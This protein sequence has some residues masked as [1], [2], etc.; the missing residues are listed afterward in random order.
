MGKPDRSLKR[1]KGRRKKKSKYAGAALNA[2]LSEALGGE[3]SRPDELLFFED[4]GVSDQVDR[5]AQIVAKREATEKQEEAEAIL[6][7]IKSA[8][9]PVQKKFV[10]VRTS[11][12]V[13]KVKEASLDVTKSPG[14]RDLWADDEPLANRPVTNKSRFVRSRPPT[15]QKVKAVKVVHPAASYNPSVDDLKEGLQKA[16]DDHLDFAKAKVYS[17]PNGFDE[18]VKRRKSRAIVDEEEKDLVS[19]DSSGSSSDED[20]AMGEE[21]EQE[22]D[23][24]GLSDPA[25]TGE[26][27]TTRERNKAK[28]K[29]MNEFLRKQ[30]L[31]KEEF[32]HQVEHL[33][34]IES[35]LVEE[36]KLQEQ[37]RQEKK[38]RMDAKLQEEP[39]A[40]IRG[41]KA[42]K[43]PTVEAVLPSELS[44]SLRKMKPHGNFLKDRFDSLHQRNLVAVGQRG[45]KKRKCVIFWEIVEELEDETN[46]TQLHHLS[47]DKQRETRCRI[48]KIMTARNFVHWK[49]E[50]LTFYFS[51]GFRRIRRSSMFQLANNL[52]K[53]TMIQR[54]MG[55]K[56][57]I[58]DSE[59]AE[60]QL[61]KK[62]KKKRNAITYL[63][64]HPLLPLSSRQCQERQVEKG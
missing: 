21:Q 18:W 55:P 15:V 17:K 37:Q 56:R 39:V 2:A 46:E 48:F 29:K 19:E 50:A 64:T 38:E 9:V 3:R 42:L 60:S 20:E 7:E 61:G 5:K 47:F 59:M 63:V 31:Q 11:N 24:K 32:A 28:N 45:K 13:D 12:G 27:M 26:R 57:R 22:N 14:L 44:G 41:H 16:V 8:E 58:G 25:M 30:K 54:Q 10:R 34:D 36:E 62:K 40:K 52:W 6:S 43:V 53:K 35:K 51:A 23:A 49:V 1:Q 4:K 33:K